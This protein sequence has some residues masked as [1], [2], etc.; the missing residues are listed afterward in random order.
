MFEGF[1]KGAEFVNPTPMEL[2]ADWGE[3]VLQSLMSEMVAGSTEKLASALERVDEILQPEAR[4]LFRQLSDSGESLSRVLIEI[5][6]LKEG[7]F[8][9]PPRAEA[10]RLSKEPLPL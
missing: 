9:S 3:A 2:K 10:S 6:R 1:C 7:G 5:Q 4:S 8:P